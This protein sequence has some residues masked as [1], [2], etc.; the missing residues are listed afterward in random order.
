MAGPMSSLRHTL[1]MASSSAVLEQQPETTTSEGKG[2]EPSSSG[3]GSSQTEDVWQN[4]EI[5]LSMYDPPAALL[6]MMDKNTPE[7]IEMVCQTALENIMQQV[8]A[9]KQRA[10]EAAAAAAAQAEAEREA[11]DEGKGKGKAADDTPQITITP[12]P[13]LAQA[14]SQIG[15][16]PKPPQKR[17]RFG[18]FRGILFKDKGGGGE[19]STSPTTTT[20]FHQSSSHQRNNS[21]STSISLTTPAAAADTAS[22]SP[23]TQFIYKH[24]KPTSDPDLSATTVECVSCLED[25]PIKE[26]IRTACHAYCRDCFS[27]LITTALENEAQWPPKCCLNPIPF[28]TISKNISDDLRRRYKEKAAE[29]RIPVESR[30][31]C[32][33]PDCGEWIRKINKADKTARCSHGHLMCIMCRNTAHHPA[34][35]SCPADRD[36]LM[37]DQL[38]EEEGWKR[39]IRCSVLVEHRDACQHMTCRCG[40]EFCYVC[41]ARWRTCSCSMGDLHNVKQRAAAKRAER[42][43]KQ[44][45]EEEWLRN[46][47]RAIEELERTE[48]RR[49]EEQRDRERRERAERKRREREA[50]ARR[51][52]RRLLDL[53]GKYEKLRS[54]LLELNDRNK[55]EIEVPWEQDHK[56]RRRRIET[57]KEEMEKKQQEEMLASRARGDRKIEQ[58][59]HQFEKEYK[60]RVLVEGRLE[61]EY[62]NVLWAFWGDKTGGM[63]TAETALRQYMLKNDRRLDEWLR[64]R[65]REMEKV[66][67]TV[68]DEI[69]I[70]EELDQT[71]RLRKEEETAKELEELEKKEKAEMKWWRLVT[72]ERIRLLSE[73]EMVE[74]ESGGEVYVESEDEVAEGSGSRDGEG[75][76]RPRKS[77]LVGSTDDEEW[78]D[79]SE[80]ETRLKAFGARY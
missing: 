56:E 21:S 65:D 12:V 33:E 63:K 39:C 29:F 34:G 80:G 19:S 40:A 67:Y 76:A 79:E 14:L 26:G 62:K 37:A 73:I 36:R 13:S 11:N 23:L 38:A 60:K 52:E 27:R 25:I 22:P 18:F 24:I 42:V 43:R 41:G 4:S 3:S 35:T 32:G 68:E 51:E 50:W 30:I 64:F 57:E 47:I 5:D 61:D 55:G 58:M 6:S 28:R 20:V 8:K 71:V 72:A 54:V 45:A 31:Y 17:S 10:D 69:A 16:P 2:K 74:R 66:R 53:D 7:T 9:E 1:N 78:E 75:S 59:E 49:K 46:A 44:D 77:S 48:R 15:G 70:R